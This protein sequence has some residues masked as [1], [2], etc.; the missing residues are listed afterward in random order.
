MR[1]KR[2]QLELKRIVE[3]AL[4]KICPLP[5]AALWLVVNH[6]AATGH[7]IRSLRVAATLHFL[8]QGSPFCC[9]EPM[10]HLGLSRERLDELGEEVRLLLHL[11]HE[12]SLDFPSGISVH[13][14]P[15]VTFQP[16]NPCDTDDV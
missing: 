9:G 13:C 1:G 14:H 2:S 6:V 15:G 8:S 7:P 3:A 16:Q 5:D 11:R 12:V 4:A 10:C